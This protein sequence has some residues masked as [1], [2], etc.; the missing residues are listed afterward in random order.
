MSKNIHQILTSIDTYASECRAASMERAKKFREE[1]DRSHQRSGRMRAHVRGSMAT[2]IDSH[3]SEGVPPEEWFWLT[4][5]Y[6]AA[7]LAHC[8]LDEP[9]DLKIR[10][11]GRNM[12]EKPIDL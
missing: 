6:C 5:K 7:A 10:R 12:K 2:L 4:L 11:L 1:T 9:V 3:Q 8:D